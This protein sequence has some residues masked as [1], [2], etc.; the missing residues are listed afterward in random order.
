MSQVKA[1]AGLWRRCPKVL[2]LT[3]GLSGHV[4]I[5]DAAR[6][7]AFGALRDIRDIRDKSS[8]VAL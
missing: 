4:H 6:A 5:V 2:I 7:A 1:S 3:N 8:Q